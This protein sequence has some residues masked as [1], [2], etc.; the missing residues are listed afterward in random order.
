MPRA[1]PR[2]QWRRQSLVIL[3]GIYTFRT[4]AMP[5]N[6]RFQW[7]PMPAGMHRR[8]EILVPTDMTDILPAPSREVIPTIC[9]AVAAIAFAPVLHVASPILAIAVETLV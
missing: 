5:L 3:N 4:N 9:I 7:S 8:S 6:L 2:F 1:A